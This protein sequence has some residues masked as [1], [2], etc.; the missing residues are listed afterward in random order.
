[1][2]I[3]C[4]VPDPA[5]ERA[6]VSTMGRFNRAANHVGQI[7]FAEQTRSMV[8]LQKR[9][10]AE[11]RGQFGL[12]AQLA[13]SAI[14]KAARALQRDKQ[15]Q[16]VFEQ[17][18]AML[19]DRK[20]LSFKG[21]GAVSVLTLAGRVQV[22]FVIVGYRPAPRRAIPGQHYLF[23]V[24][25]IFYLAVVL[26]VPDALSAHAMSAMNVDVEL[27]FQTEGIPAVG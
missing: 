27:L 16:P 14:S 13:I 11:L 18:G 24:N 5:Q 6:L 9:V 21:M 1:M 3:L 12:P 26:D 25:N 15:L 17:E 7:A 8:K 4:L 22:A 20:T 19:Y 23:L 2:L 10:Y